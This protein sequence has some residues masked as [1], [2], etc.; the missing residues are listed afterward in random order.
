MPEILITTY[1]ELNS[2][3]D[4]RPSYSSDPVVQIQESHVPLVAF[5]RFLYKAVGEQWRWYDRNAWSDEKL[6]NYLSQSHIRVY[7]L[8]V[9]GTPAGYIE[10]DH[11]PNRET[12]IACFGLIEPFFGR[13]YGKHLLSFGIQCAL[14]SGA[15]RVWLH[16]CN[17]D[18]DIALENYK[19]R[20]FSVYKTTEE[21]MPELYT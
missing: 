15:K 18:S 5:Y 13:G 12:E 11:Q 14:D 21:P 4:F 1:L 8:Y 17:L 7:V 3:Q 9:S 2:Q 16:T 6:S 20:G 19:K 10:L